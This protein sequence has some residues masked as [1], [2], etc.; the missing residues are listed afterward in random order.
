[1]N[2]FKRDEAIK[3]LLDLL[4]IPRLIFHCETYDSIG[5][6]DPNFFNRYEIRR[7]EREK[8]AR[9]FLENA[10]DEDL[11]ELSETPGSLRSFELEHALFDPPPWYAGGFGVEIS[12]ADFA[13]WA[14]MD[15]WSLEEATCLSIGF[16]PKK[17]P[18]KTKFGPPG[19]ALD[20]YH[21]RT[22][23]FKRADFYHAQSQDQI[24]PRAFVEWALKKE[25]EIPK[26]LELAVIENGEIK[27]PAMLGTV[28][29]RKHDSALKVI[30]GLIA[31]EYGY[32]DG[33]VEKDIK[34]ATMAG[35]ARLGLNIDRKTLNC[36][37]DEVVKSANRFHSEQEKRD[38]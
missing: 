12:K 13:Y 3:S 25:I 20:F 1:M 17:M 36:L 18:E 23:L 5:P 6:N 37:F 19:N 31:N 11:W 35:L 22:E 34:Q 16:K 26:E 21:G 15:F 14:K 30:L 32:R 28:D 9:A 29:A 38:K 2:I 27:R 24:K 33:K 10:A 4:D 8:A 7:R